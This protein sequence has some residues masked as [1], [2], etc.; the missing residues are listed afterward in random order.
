MGSDIEKLDCSEDE[1][2]KDH[3]K[4]VIKSKRK[5]LNTQKVKKEIMK[6]K[7]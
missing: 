5:K 1:E 2:V 3:I 4:H 6:V 7:L